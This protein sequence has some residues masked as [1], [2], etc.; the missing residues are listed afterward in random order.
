M[1]KKKAQKNKVYDTII[2]FVSTKNDCIF[3]RLKILRNKKKKNM[4]I[5][6]TDNANVM[7][8]GENYSKYEINLGMIRNIVQVRQFA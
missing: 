8:R 5:E 7:Q 1:K 6:Q 2:I 4:E 3:C